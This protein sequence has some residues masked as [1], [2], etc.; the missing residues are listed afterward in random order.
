MLHL[1]YSPDLS[2][3][4]KNKEKFKNRQQAAPEEYDLSKTKKNRAQAAPEE[5]PVH[6]KS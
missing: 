2:S 6:N 3:D 4:Y 1:T 5:A